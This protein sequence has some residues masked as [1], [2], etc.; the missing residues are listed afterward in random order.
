MAR[1]AAA[2]PLPA[3]EPVPEPVEEATPA[4]IPAPEPVPAAPKRIK[5]VAGR[6]RVV[7]HDDDGTPTSYLFAAE[8]IEVPAAHAERLIGRPGLAVVP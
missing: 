5:S 3:D 8:P 4:P 7:V 1:K 2:K 6:Q